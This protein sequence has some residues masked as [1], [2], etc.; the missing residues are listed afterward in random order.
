MTAAQ[1]VIELAKVAAQS[2]FDKQATE[3][4]LLDV[5]EHLVITDLFLICT[6]QNERQ[7]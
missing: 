1:S 2:A 7:V 5:S 6:A 4:V 3:I